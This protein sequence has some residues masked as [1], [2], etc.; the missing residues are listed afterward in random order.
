[1]VE[2]N[3]WSMSPDVLLVLLLDSGGGVGGHVHGDGGQ[4]HV[5][6]HLLPED[7]QSAS[8]TC[9]RLGLGREL[10]WGLGWRGGQHPPGR[11]DALLVHQLKAVLVGRT[12]RC[13]TWW[14]GE[15]MMGWLGEKVMG[16][17]GDA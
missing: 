10:G 12:Q 8:D 11:A 1:M 6:H 14:L 13:P 3:L 16:W 15:M 5:L 4:P 17:L 9:V 2:P 7:V